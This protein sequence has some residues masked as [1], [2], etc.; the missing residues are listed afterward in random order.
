LAVIFAIAQLS[1]CF[2][3]RELVVVAMAVRN[4]ALAQQRFRLE[5]LDLTFGDFDAV[6]R[7]LQLYKLSK[8]GVS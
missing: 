6:T 2:Y 4:A 5:N 1:C 3:C 8:N 7:L